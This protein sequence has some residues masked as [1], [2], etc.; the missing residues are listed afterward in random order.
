MLVSLVHS[1]VDNL[2]AVFCVIYSLLIFV[3]DA[4]GDHM[5]ETYSS[6]GLVMDL[7]VEN[8]VSFYFHHVVDVS[9]LNN[10]VYCLACFYYCIFYEFVVCEFGVESQS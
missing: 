8:I 9:A 7:Y 1:V 3:C 2:S 6:M 5:V 10:Y 4:S